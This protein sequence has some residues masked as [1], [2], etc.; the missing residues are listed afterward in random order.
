M[1]ILSYIDLPASQLQTQELMM[2]KIRSHRVFN[3]NKA[4]NILSLI[5]C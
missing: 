5:L 2:S 1:T 4:Y 3:T